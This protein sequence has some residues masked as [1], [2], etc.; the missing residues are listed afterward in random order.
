MSNYSLLCRF[1]CNF[2]MSKEIENERR[3]SN[4]SKFIPKEFKRFKKKKKKMG[5]ISKNYPLKILL[6]KF[7]KGQYSKF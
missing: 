3:T 6:Y 4:I 2:S 7:L 5:I 1:K